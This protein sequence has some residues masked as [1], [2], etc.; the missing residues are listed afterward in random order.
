MQVKLHPAVVHAVLIAF[1]CMTMLLSIP[2][3]T[4]S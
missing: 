4:V 1:L 3:Y 2:H